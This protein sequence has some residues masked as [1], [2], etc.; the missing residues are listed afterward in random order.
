[1]QNQKKV[2]KTLPNIGDKPHQPNSSYQFKKTN[3]SG[4]N[5]NFQHEWFATFPWLHYSEVEDKAYCFYCVKCI[6]EKLSTKNFSKS[7][8]FTHDGFNYWNKASERF[9][10]HQESKE[11]IETKWKVFEA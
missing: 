7:E 2:I 11:H 4:K 10:M 5:R 6:K 3:F 9:R 1:V 8:S